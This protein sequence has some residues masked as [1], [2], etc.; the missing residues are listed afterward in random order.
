MLHFI[1]QYVVRY[2]LYYSAGFFALITTNY[3]ATIIPLYIQNAVDLLANKDSFNLIKPFLI[4]IIIFAS[5]LLV[6]RTLSRVLIFF[7][8]RFVEYDL[9]DRLFSHL[10]GLFGV[11]KIKK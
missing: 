4:K 11:S 8:G 1:R 6:V 7:P 3:I 9:R 10:L 2:W 5:I